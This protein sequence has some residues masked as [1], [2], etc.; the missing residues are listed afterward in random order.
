MPL[1]GIAQ[2]IPEQIDAQHEWDVYDAAVRV[3]L[4]L[5]ESTPADV[6]DDPLPDTTTWVTR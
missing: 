3:D 5:N 6:L 1:Q 4:G 2:R